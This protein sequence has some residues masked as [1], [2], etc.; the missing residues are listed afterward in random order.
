MSGCVYRFSHDVDTIDNLI[1]VSI[2][3]VS[4]CLLQSTASL[5]VI[6]VVFPYFLAPLAVIFGVLYITQLFYRATSRELKRLESETRSP[7][8]S[9][10]SETLTGLSSVRTY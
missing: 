3:W 9:H 4:V 2:A 1:M 7:V 5:I 6:S 10:F 8:F